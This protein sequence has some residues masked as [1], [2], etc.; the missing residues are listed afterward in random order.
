MK[1]W[2]CLAS[3]CLLTGTSM[4]QAADVAAG[5]SAGYA[6]RAVRYS[7]GCPDPYSCHP[8]YGGY[9]PWGGTAYWSS[10]SPGPIYWRK[11]VYRKHT[12]LRVRH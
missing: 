5:A 10:F 7:A 12:V 2:T 9:G 8:L 6:T 4:V 3:A 1:L 11:H